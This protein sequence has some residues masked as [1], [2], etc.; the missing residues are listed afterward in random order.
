MA[1]APNT[2]TQLKPGLD[3][4]LGTSLQ[5]DV[6]IVEVGREEMNA[7]KRGFTPQAE[8]WN[9]RLAMLGLSVGLGVLILGRLVASLT[10]A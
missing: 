10:A 7:W 6:E 1:P 5:G 2:G 3:G 4:S 8:I 9:G